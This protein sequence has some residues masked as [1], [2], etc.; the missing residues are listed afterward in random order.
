MSGLYAAGQEESSTCKGLKT[1]V[2]VGMIMAMRLSVCGQRARC[3]LS[4]VVS[5][6]PRTPACGRGGVKDGR[7]SHK[8]QFRIVTH[9]RAPSVACS[10]SYKRRSMLT[11]LI[12]G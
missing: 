10:L 11:V 2:S 7:T 9:R 1:R 3:L 6:P 12:R 4:A 5:Q 8:N